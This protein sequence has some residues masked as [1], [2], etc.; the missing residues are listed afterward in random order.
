[1]SSEEFAIKV[2]G[3]SKCNQIYDRPQD[4][5]KQSIYSR[6]QR[7]MGRTSTHYFQEFWAFKNGCSLG[8]V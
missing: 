4:R 1:M 3:L 2:N 7:L 8:Y 5:L 6:L